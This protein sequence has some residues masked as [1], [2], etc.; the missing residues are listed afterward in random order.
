MIKKTNI[1]N[2]DQIWNLKWKHNPH[3]VDMENIQVHKNLEFFITK[4]LLTCKFPSE[5]VKN[6]IH[7]F[8]RKNADIC[9]NYFYVKTTR[10]PVSGSR[11]QF[12]RGFP[13]LWKIH[14]LVVRPYFQR[15]SRVVPDRVSGETC[16]LTFWFT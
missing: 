14:Q 11:S 4:R 2:I 12:V 5:S 3:T 1:W 7:R 8:Q 13:R 15:G 16:I 10:Q 6:A 9:I